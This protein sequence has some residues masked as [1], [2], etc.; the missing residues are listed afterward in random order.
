MDQYSASIIIPAYNQASRLELTLL[1][2]S[3][4]ITGGNL[5]FEIIVVDDGSTDDTA[6]VVKRFQQNLP[7]VYIYQENKGR[8]GARNTGIK[9]SK[10]E[11]LLFCDADRPVVNDW[12]QNHI[13]IHNIEVPVVGVGE[14]K[15]FFFSR[16]EKVHPMLSDAM[17]ENF[18][19]FRR[20]ARP[21]SYWECVK[22]TFDRENIC[23]SSV[24]WMTTLAG[25]LS[26]RKSLLEQ[27][28][29]FDEDFKGWGFEHFELGYRFHQAGARFKYVPGGINY[30]LA[31][32]R[33]E[34]FY[35]EQIDR[36]MNLFLRKTKDSR[37]SKLF[38][39]LRGEMTLGDLDDFFLEGKT[40]SDLPE[41][42]KGTRFVA[43]LANF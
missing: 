29:L 17:K 14:I 13:N 12:L 20:L 26:V 41:E 8:A 21:Y 35:Q 27:A 24:P 3:H 33:E 37:V 30:H 25:N 6:E 36:S 31:H 5:R 15:E 28:G 2:F 19:P 7:I 34:N 23:R 40:T 42:V 43:P 10:G 32:E 11:V 18:K 22:K 4:Q 16:L 9:A 38:A 1:S 39:F